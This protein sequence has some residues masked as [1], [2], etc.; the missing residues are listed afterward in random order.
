[1]NLQKDNRLENSVVWLTGGSGFIGSHLSKKLIATGT[2]KIFLLS[3]KNTSRP[4]LT[5]FDDQIDRIEINYQDMRH[6]NWLLNN[7]RIAKPAYLI[8]A[9]WGSVGDPDSILHQSSNVTSTTNLF[10][11]V[12][13]EELR[14]AIFFGSIDEYG[15]RFGRIEES[16]V[17]VLPISS[18]AI[19]K[20]IAARKLE[21]LAK[22]SRISMQHCLISNVYGPNQR[23]ETLLPQMKKA[24]HF[25]F[26]GESYYRDYIYVGDLT[27][28]L[29]TLLTS[30]CSGR[31]NIGS[32][33][34][35]HCFDFAR[36]AWA[37]MGKNPKN[38]TFIHPEVQD[39]SL[40]K[41]FN[42][43]RLRSQ[44]PKDMTICGI[45]FGLAKT[46]LTL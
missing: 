23:D 25:E 13:K 41:C 14:K 7:A 20:S 16:H 46:V 32:G 2:K 31:L 5:Q 1:M 18:Y 37:L 38:L 19:G 43:S 4:S 9:G 22:Q 39:E 45:E 10:N 35:T 21:I 36:K 6:L 27:K 29:T 17:S 12:P 24:T 33:K 28:I 40:M 42:I 34:T 11:A 26:R 15:K 30:D 44:L 8:M 3:N